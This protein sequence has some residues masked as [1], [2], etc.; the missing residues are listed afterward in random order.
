MGENRQ[1]DDETSQPGRADIV[2]R[3]AARGS[4]DVR[5]TR[6]MSTYRS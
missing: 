3:E 1:A 6:L 2:L 4:D 5:G